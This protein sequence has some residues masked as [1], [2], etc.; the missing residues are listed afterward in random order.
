[1]SGCVDEASWL[2]FM[3]FTLLLF[4]VAVAVVDVEDEGAQLAEDPSAID[5]V[6]EISEVF[7]NDEGLEVAGSS[8][9]CDGI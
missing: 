7:G 2:L 4:S 1:M 5:P 3:L 9:E 6:E 8:C